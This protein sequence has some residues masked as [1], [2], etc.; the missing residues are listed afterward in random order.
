MHEHGDE[1]QKVKEKHLGKVMSRNR[2]Q[3]HYEH[4]P[5]MKASKKV[6]ENIKTIANKIEVFQGREWETAMV[7]SHEKA[8][9]DSEDEEVYKGQEQKKDIPDFLRFEVWVYGFCVSPDLQS[10]T[11]KLRKN[12]DE[13]MFL[14]H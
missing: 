6:Q 1:R 8:D 12:E 7:I 9:F 11:L 2:V 10:V 4:T 13:E 3:I 5:L 14:G